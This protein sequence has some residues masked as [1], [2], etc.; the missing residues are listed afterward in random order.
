VPIAAVVV[1][2]APKNTIIPVSEGFYN[3]SV[4]AQRFHTDVQMEAPMERTFRVLAINP[5]STSTKIACFDGSRRI[6]EESISH[7]AETLSAYETMVEQLP[8]RREEI[9]ASLDRAEISLSSLDAVVGRG[10]LLYPLAGGTYGVNTLMVADLKAGVLGEHA[11]N[12]GGI[13][14]REIADA[15][16]DTAGGGDRTIPAYIVDPVV[17]D[18]LVD[19]ARPSGIPEIPRVSIFHALNQKAVARRVARD[20]G[21]RYEELALVVVH[22]GGGITV[23]AHLNGK[24]I[25]VNDGLNGEGPFTPERSGG[26][27]A[28]KLID[29]CYSG[30]YS[31]SEMKGKVKGKGGLVAYLGTNDA[32]EVVHRINNGDALARDVYRAMAWQVAKQIGAAAAALG[33]RPD[34]IVLT[35]GIAHDD[36]LT[37]WITERISWVADVL[38]YPGEDEMTALAE[39]ALRVLEGREDPRTYRGNEENG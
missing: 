39:G 27:A 38:R 24:V 4:L 2:I 6:M 19:E 37:G 28:L 14:A 20:R 36:V 9:F 30:N 13:L 26:V 10:G 3:H 11:S 18:E 8:F 25:D 15:A 12:L 17:V 1:I 32:R 29:L 21:R 7:S 34:A 22:L 35:G 31:K 23:G 33:R 16:A 5:G